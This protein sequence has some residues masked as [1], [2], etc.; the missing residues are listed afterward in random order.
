MEAILKYNLPEEKE[1]FE[2]AVNASKML[3]L[4]FDYDQ[5]LRAQIKYAPDEMSQ[6]KFEA[7]EECKEMLHAMLKEE[8]LSILL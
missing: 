1:D 5:W 7:F 2:M 6:E 8:N 4:L 3:G